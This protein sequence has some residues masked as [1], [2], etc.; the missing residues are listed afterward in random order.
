MIHTSPIPL[1]GIVP[2]PFVRTNYGSPLTARAMVGRALEA[3]D[4]YVVQI[5][6][7]EGILWLRLVG[8]DGE[9][10]VAGGAAVF[11]LEAGVPGR[12]SRP[13]K[14]R[15]PAKGGRLGN[16]VGEVEGELSLPRPTR[17]I[18]FSPRMIIT[19]SRRLKWRRKRAATASITATAATA[20]IHR[21][22]VIR[23][24]RMAEPSGI[25]TGKGRYWITVCTSPLGRGLGGKFQL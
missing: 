8:F 11:L 12:R 23:G 16:L 4:I 25:Q 19:R 14:R 3:R 7:V 18:T 22:V 9:P 10:G 1:S 15:K 20:I 5:L 21:R 24:S 13:R 6:K 2:R 17:Q